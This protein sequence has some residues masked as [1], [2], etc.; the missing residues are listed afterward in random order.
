MEALINSLGTN[1]NAA[2]YLYWS[3]I[4]GSLWTAADII[5]CLYVIRLANLLRAPLALRHHVIPYIVLALTVVPALF[6]PIVPHGAAFFRLE[7]IVTI[8]HFL[9]LLYILGINL[10]HGPRMFALILSVGAGIRHTSPVNPDTSRTNESCS[11]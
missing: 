3:R 2:D 8:P 10:R 1:F 5:L 9:I 4:E 6:I 7:V 11:P